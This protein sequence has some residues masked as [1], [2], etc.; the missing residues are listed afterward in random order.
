[1][2][3]LGVERLTQERAVAIAGYLTTAF[4]LIGKDKGDARG[5]M[6][7]ANKR[8]GGGFSRFTHFLSFAGQ[9]EES[10]SVC[11]Q[12]FLLVVSI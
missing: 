4:V 2:N 5:V 10:K 11:L 6:G 9:W 7:L 3:P 1:M 12:I 8:Q